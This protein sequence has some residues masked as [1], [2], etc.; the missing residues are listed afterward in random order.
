MTERRARKVE[1]GLSDFEVDRRA[2]L[3]DGPAPYTAPRARTLHFAQRTEWRVRVLFMGICR[4]RDDDGNGSPGAVV[5]VKGPPGLP[6]CATDVSTIGA[7]RIGC[8]KLFKRERFT[9]W[10]PV[11]S[12]ARPTARGGSKNFGERGGFDHG[13]A[14]VL[15][16]EDDLASATWMGD[17]SRSQ[18]FSAARAVARP[19]GAHL[20][21][22][23]R[24]NAYEMIAGRGGAGRGRKKPRPQWG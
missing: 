4:A 20:R 18:G 11:W 24:G 9:E 12:G 13:Y 14:A 23:I 17:R 2:G 16:L 10:L 6:P 15:A 1:L 19:D 5:P 8:C 22:F 21:S 3:P 7:V